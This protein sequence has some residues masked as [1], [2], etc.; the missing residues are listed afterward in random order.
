MGEG[1]QRPRQTVAMVYQF[2]EGSPHIPTELM[3][4]LVNGHTIIEIDEKLFYHF[5]FRFRQKV[6]FDSPGR[7]GLSVGLEPWQ[8]AEF[9]VDDERYYVRPARFLDN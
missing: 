9:F 7:F 4:E 5:K 1:Q 3:H 8:I 6:F 2:Q